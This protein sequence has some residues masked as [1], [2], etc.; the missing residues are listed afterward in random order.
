MLTPAKTPTLVT[1]AL[2][3][4][5]CATIPAG[6]SVM[7]LPGSQKSFETFQAE[8]EICRSW[9]DHSIGVSPAHAAGER[10]VAGAAVGTAMG[11]AA[12]AAIGAASGAAGPGAAIGAGAGLLMGTAGGASQGE[13]T[14]MSL[15]RRYDTAYMQC[16]YAKGN[17]IPMARGVVPDYAEQGPPPLPPAPRPRHHPRP[18][19]G[20]PPPPPPDA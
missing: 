8:D 17:Q 4:T 16:M 19:A 14:G 7:V 1:L 13:R 9:A 20:P 10:T 2:A 6:P 5:A 12:G 3:F 18:P 15:Q 11:A